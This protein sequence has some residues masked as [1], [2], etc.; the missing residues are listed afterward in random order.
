MTGTPT[1]WFDGTISEVGGLNAGTMYPFF[2]HHVTTRAAVDSPLEIALACDYDST[3]NEGSVEATVT[4]TSGSA[5]SGNIHFVLVEDDIP[6]NWS[7][8][9]E[10][11]QVMRD[12]IPD[13]NGQAV[14]IPASDTI[15][16]TRDFT[17][18]ATWNEQ[19][20]RIIVFVQATNR[21]IY[22]G[23]EVSILPESHMVYYGMTVTELTG[24]GNGYGEPGEEIE[25]TAYAKN[26]GSSVYTL[27][28]TVE[29]TDP[30]ITVLSSIVD[31]FEIQPGDVDDVITW[32]FDIS[33]SC[34]D[35]HLAEFNLTFGDGN[36]S[37]VPFLVTTRSGFADDMESGVGE[38][39]HSGINDNWHLTEHKSS[40]PTHSWY[41]G[42]ENLWYYTNQNDA[43]LVSPYFIASPES[44]LHFYHQYDLEVGWDYSYVEIDNGSGWWRTF[45]EYNGNQATWIGE[46]YPLSEYSGQT[47]R[48]RFRFVSDYSAYEEGW[49]IDDVLVPMLGVQES[50][51]PENLRAISLN[52]SPNPF[53]KQTQIRYMIQDA[54]DMTQEPKMNIYDATG[55]LVK[56]FDLESS[57]MDRASSVIWD[58]TDQL[59]RKL[60]GGVYFITL[61]NF[62]SKIVKKAILVK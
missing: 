37:P 57:S 20:C 8:G 35:P 7:G 46:S 47:V 5:V 27:P 60:P 30:H 10:L 32:A 2:R 28:A 12:M 58:G 17:V 13:A 36:E 16:R 50:G 51:T 38:W 39:T 29:C 6:Y 4:N 23:A 44:T 26:M 62:D 53:A 3:T 52:V 48:L 56:S 55:R 45:D 33:A 18:D 40:S 22:Q 11:D 49:Y 1:T 25:V 15:I 19:N 54:R 61:Q 41:C 42:L 34:P 21:S 59:D 9:S 31:T 14:T 43:S 24:N